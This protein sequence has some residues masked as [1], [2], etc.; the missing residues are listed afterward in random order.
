MDYCTISQARPSELSFLPV[1]YLRQLSGVD[2]P[3]IVT[4]EEDA[5]AAFVAPRLRTIPPGNAQSVCDVETLCALAG[6]ERAGK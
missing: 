5:V 4:L 1:L 3:S 6:L 2:C